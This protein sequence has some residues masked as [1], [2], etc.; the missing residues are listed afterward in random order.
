MEIFGGKM[1]FVKKELSE[2]ITPAYQM[3]GAGLLQI[4]LNV[5]DTIVVGH[6]STLELAGLAAAHCT[7]ILFFTFFAGFSSGLDYVFGESSSV[8]STEKNCEN[9][10]ASSIIA[11]VSGLIS[12]AGTFVLAKHFNV[13]GSPPEVVASSQRYLEV[14]AISLPMTMFFLQIQ[15]FNQALGNAKRFLDISI[16]INILNFALNILFVFGYENVIPAMG[17]AG[18]GWCT[19]ICRLTMCVFAVYWTRNLLSERARKSNEQL[20]FASL[21]PKNVINTIRKM[22]K[23]GTPGGIQYVGDTVVFSLLTL[24]ATSYGKVPGS[25]NQVVYQFQGIAYMVPASLSALVSMKTASYLSSTSKESAIKVA[26]I[27]ILLTISASLICVIPM[28]TVPRAIVSVFT[29]DSAVIA[30]AA[31]V[32]RLSAVLQFSYAVFLAMSGAMRGIKEVK[33]PLYASF[34]GVYL[35]GIPAGYLISKL[36]SADVYSLWAG[37]AMGLACSATI[38]T[39]FW[40]DS[41]KDI[42]WFAYEGVS[43]PNSIRATSMVQSTDWI[44]WKELKK[45]GAFEGI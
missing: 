42:H 27:G 1:E 10:V 12:V 36:Y 24:V 38:S 32:L 16:W 45:K 17:S 31:D 2:Y 25:A 11:I 34:A 6:Y 8:G 21:S 9:L 26:W 29:D 15:K 13:F 40:L 3:V 39:Y 44:S 43:K 20:A 4:M 28:A 30:I 22:I 18:A 23:L 37:I 7:Y 19:L 14:I 41:T 35:V 5:S 33:R